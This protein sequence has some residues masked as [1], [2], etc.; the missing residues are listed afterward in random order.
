M[1]MKY[2]SAYRAR[3]KWRFI[4]P[5]L[6]GVLVIGLAALTQVQPIKSR[7]AWRVEV[8]STYLRGVVNPIEPMPA[9]H[10]AAAASDPLTPTPRPTDTPDPATPTPTLEQS[11]TPTPTPTP[12][13]GQAKLEPAAYEKQDMNNCGPATLTMFLRM[14][15]WEGDQYVIAD[16]VKP[17]P[18][19]AMSTSMSCTPS[20]SQ[21]QLAATGFRVGALWTRCGP[22]SLW[23]SG[24]IEE[25]FQWR[26]VLAKHD[27][28]SGTLLI[29]ATMIP[30]SVHHPGLL[31]RRKPHR[32]LPGS[33]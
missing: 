24:E 2:S 33:R 13:P 14:F 16:Q 25:G 10:T 22:S 28:W 19:T 12:L 23:L 27:R 4:L 21:R 7:L 20:H 31:C 26:G 15:G 17:I 18:Q 29:T 6:A 9:P 11:P 32:Q 30:A 3:K 8:A 1:V 5:A